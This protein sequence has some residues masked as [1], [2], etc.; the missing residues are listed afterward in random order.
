MIITNIGHVG[1]RLDGKTIVLNPSLLAMTKLSNPVDI[2]SKVHGGHYP[3]HRI[4]NPEL[5]TQI[6][7][8]CYGEML[9]AA[10]Q[11]LK[12]CCEFDISRL[13]GTCSLR[14]DGRQH[15]IPGKMPQDDILVIARHLLLH[16]II[17]NQKD[18]PDYEDKDKGKWSSEFDA[19]PLA[20]MAVAHLGMS[21]EA[22]WSMTMTSF[23][24]AMDAK[25]PPDK[26]KKIP[27]Q[28]KYEETMDWAE[29][30]MAA[31]AQRNG[32]H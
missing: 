23:R 4:D 13:T 30:M 22:A 27:T 8:R 29:R 6:A 10:I 14:P 32:L 3:A 16:G 31:D 26:K 9:E 12:V 20:Y 25:F 28:K 15:L 7:V 18:D 11:V 2:F 19:R 5:M 24:A 17:G 21:E 1:I